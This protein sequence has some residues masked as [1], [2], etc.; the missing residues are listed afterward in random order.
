MKKLF[1]KCRHEDSP[2]EAGLCHMFTS[3]DWE[4]PFAELAE[5]YGVVSIQVFLKCANP[6]LCARTPF[7]SILPGYHDGPLFPD[8]YQW[9]RSE[10]ALTR[11][12]ETRRL[13]ESDV[14]EELEA[15]GNPT[16]AHARR[17]LAEHVE[18]FRLYLTDKGNTPAHVKDQAAKVKRIIDGCGFKRIGDIT[19]GV[20]HAYL[21]DLRKL[22]PAAPAD[23]AVT[24][25]VSGTA[26]SQR[27]IAE[28]FGVSRFTVQQWQR[29][30]GNRR[31]LLNRKTLARPGTVGR[32]YTPPDSNGQ[33]SVP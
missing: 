6:K 14:A 16:T 15:S 29:A 25:K 17:P 22:A 1:E 24:R 18:D 33:P 21:T 7:D 9:P 13:R 27:E 10:E 12:P 32:K 31:N 23:Q 5:A 30:G 20:V 19:A 2:S 3:I 26:K 4:K 8:Y 11:G 28:R